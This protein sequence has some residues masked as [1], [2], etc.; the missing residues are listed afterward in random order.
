MLYGS[1]EDIKKA[2]KSLV[3]ENIDLVIPDCM[4]Y[5]QAIKDLVVETSKKPVILPRTSAGRIAAEI[6]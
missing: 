4:G 5:T 1:T 2:D 6:I 3:S